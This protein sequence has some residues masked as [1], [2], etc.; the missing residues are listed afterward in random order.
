MTLLHARFAKQ[1]L[2][3]SNGVLIRAMEKHR[4]QA[5]NDSML[6]LESIDCVRPKLRNAFDDGMGAVDD[7][8]VRTVIDGKLEWRRVSDRPILNQM[9]TLILL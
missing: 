9:H 7:A 5:I 4:L 2:F 6:R 1:K 8:A 3:V